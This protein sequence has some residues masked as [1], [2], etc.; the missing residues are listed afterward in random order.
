MKGVWEVLL[1]PLN[2]VFGELGNIVEG[3]VGLLDPFGTNTEPLW[4]C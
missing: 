4:V 3:T 2:D 1:D